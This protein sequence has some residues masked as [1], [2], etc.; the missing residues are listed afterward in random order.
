MTG[1][2]RTHLARALAPVERQRVGPEIVAPERPIEPL[3]Q[4]LRLA[5]QRRARGP[6]GRGARPAA[7]P[8]AWLRR[9]IPAPR[10]ARSGL[11]RACR[12]RGTP[13]R[14]SPSSP[15]ARG[16]SAI[17]AGVFDEAVAVDV[18]VLVDPAS[19]RSTWSHSPAMNVPVAGALVVVAGKDHEQRRRVDAA[20][21]AAE[22]HL[23]EARPSRRVRVSCRI[24]PGSASCAGVGRDRLRGGEI[25][26]HAAREVR[27][28]PRAPRAP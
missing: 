8:A 25:R 21:V 26:E 3:A 15:G 9:R 24:F 23:A 6:R 17:A 28:R 11:R 13:N 5:Q 12:L 7:R 19:A 20:V 22:W 1:V 27:V 4:L 14:W 16:R 2:R 18:A 10:R